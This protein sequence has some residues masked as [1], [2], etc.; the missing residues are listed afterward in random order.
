M[1]QIEGLPEIYNHSVGMFMFK[2]S[3]S[4]LLNIFSNFFTTNQEFH[5]Y[6]TRKANKLRIP[7]VKT[8]FASKFIKKTG[9]EYWNLLED[10]IT[11]TLQIGAFKKHL[12]LYILQNY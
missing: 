7:F 3:R 12:K 1:N 9:V 10:S 4:L 8:S 6:P 5:R 11:S 2:F